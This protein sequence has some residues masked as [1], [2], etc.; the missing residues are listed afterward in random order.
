MLPRYRSPR[1][2][3]TSDA[4]ENSNMT[5][6]SKTHKPNAPFPSKD[7]ILRASLLFNFILLV[8]LFYSGTCPPTA[9]T[10]NGH[11][12]SQLQGIEQTWHGGHPIADHKGSCWCGAEDGYCMCTPSL[13]IDLIL[14]AQP[15]PQDISP[16]IW[17]VRRKDTSQLAT[18]G[19]FVNVGETVEQAVHREL[20][21]EMGI[22][23]QAGDD[24]L[25]LQGVYSDPGRD[26]R[27]HTASAVYSVQLHE[28]IQP[29]AADD[30]KQVAKISLDEVESLEFFADHKT[31][32]L[33][34]RQA[35]QGGGGKATVKT[36]HQEQKH[37]MNNR[38]ALYIQRSVCTT[39]EKQQ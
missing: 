27:R 32:L 8:A 26:N 9:G 1:S 28:D 2:K 30:V 7:L 33:D 17:V 13:A 18:M 34:Y 35:L 4:N 15:Q 16:Q 29:R 36:L 12:S 37:D 10:D 20:R 3:S 24:H 23:L 25:Q 11:N 38:A 22:T 5:S 21:E 14:L 19:G 39:H 31:I 6:Y